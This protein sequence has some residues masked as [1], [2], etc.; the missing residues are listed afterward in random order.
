MSAVDGLAI[1]VEA[2]SASSWDR[3]PEQAWLIRVRRGQRSVIVAWGL[4]RPAAEHIAERI[5]DV[6]C[7]P[8]RRGCR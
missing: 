8:A 6:V 2:G 7:G 4:S 1:E 5:A 3:P